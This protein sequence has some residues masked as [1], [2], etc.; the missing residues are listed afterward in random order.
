MPS[1]VNS[2]ASTASTANST[3]GVGVEGVLPYSEVCFGGSPFSFD[4]L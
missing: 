3:V 4:E 2:T 1:L